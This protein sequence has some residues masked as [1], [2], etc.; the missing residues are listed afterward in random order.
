MRSCA[1]RTSIP[2][3]STTWNE[4]GWRLR[5]AECHRWTTAGDD[6][7]SQRLVGSVQD[8]PLPTIS[9][10][11]GS[12]GRQ[13]VPRTLNKLTS[14]YLQEAS[15]DAAAGFRAMRAAVVA[16]GP[17]DKVTC[18]LIV[19]SGLALLG[20]EDAFKTHARRLIEAGTSR[21]AVEHAVLVT[22]CSTSTLFQVA[23]AIQWLDDIDAEI[24]AAKGA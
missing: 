6:G 18:E 11:F 9:F 22:L 19:I 21:A 17:L 15:A 16:A 1:S 24:K 13:F 4:R 20:Y 2:R 7:S 10:W 5:C 3:G 8:N 23:R 12:Q 14:A